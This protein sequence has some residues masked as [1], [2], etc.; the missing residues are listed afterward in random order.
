MEHQRRPAP[1]GVVQ[2]EP[3]AAGALVRAGEFGV[4]G[5]ELGA[6]A[7][8]ELGFMLA[9]ALAATGA[10]MV[11]LRGSRVTRSDHFAWASPR[12]RHA[13]CLASPPKATAGDHQA[14]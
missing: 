3:A 14:E 10:V 11:G 2:E 9:A 4:L 8:Y 5:E 13:T 7:G 1:R 12:S 6:V